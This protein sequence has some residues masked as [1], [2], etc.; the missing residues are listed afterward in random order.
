MKRIVCVFISFCLALGPIP[1]V[2]AQSSIF[3]CDPHLLNWIKF[4][5]SPITRLPYSFYIAPKDKKLV[6]RQAAY[7][8]ELVV[9][10]HYQ[11]TS[12]R[13]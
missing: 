3:A 6:Y 9:T 7:Q 4:N 2:L 5:V 8:I 11:K 10:C 1:N 13:W 12:S